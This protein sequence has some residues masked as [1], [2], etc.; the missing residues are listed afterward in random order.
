M[1]AVDREGWMEHQAVVEGTI[2]GL[3]EL[4]EFHFGFEGIQIERQAGDSFQFQRGRR[5]DVIV[6]AFNGDLSLGVLHAAQ[7]V[8]QLPDGVGDQ[9]AKIARVD[10]PVG[11]ARPQL[12]GSDAAHAVLQNGQT[13]FVQMTVG[14]DD[15]VGTEQIAVF[16]YKIGDMRRVKITASRL[17]AIAPNRYEG[18]FLMAAWQRQSGDLE[19]AL[20][21]L[22]KSAA[23]TMVESSPMLFRGL[24]LRELGEKENAAKA[25][26]EALRIDPANR[27][28]ELLL[29]AV[30]END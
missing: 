14:G 18:Y 20:A 2:Q 26:A 21:S 12:K 24:V 13:T 5:D 10:I 28:A 9:P 15:Q 11:A 8:D 3:I 1:E 22:N 30:L 19:G 4:I 16:T 27:D 7:Q 6:Q 25:F 23:M 17:T 29:S